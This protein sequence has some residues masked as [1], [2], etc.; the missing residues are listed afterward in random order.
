ML[1]KIEK[2]QLWIL[3]MHEYKPT[4]LKVGYQRD[5]MKIRIKMAHILVEIAPEVYGLY[6]TYENLKSVL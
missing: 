1:T 4:I 6:I 5:M 2:L 3:K